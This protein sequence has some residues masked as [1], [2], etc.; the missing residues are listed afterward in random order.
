MGRGGRRAEGVVVHRGEL[1]GDRGVRGRQRA[2]LP[3]GVKRGLGCH[4]GVHCGSRGEQ[5]EGGRKLVPELLADP[6]AAQH[7]QGPVCLPPLHQVVHHCLPVLHTRTTRFT[8]YPPAA[9]QG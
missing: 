6:R 9:L 5:H 1:A 7:W 8:H 4:P 3:G 2:D